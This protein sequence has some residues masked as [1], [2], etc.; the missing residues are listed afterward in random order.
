MCY[1]I[2]VIFG[3]W[4]VLTFSRLFRRNAPEVLPPRAQQAAFDVFLS[5]DRDDFQFAVR[6]NSTFSSEGLAV[7]WDKKIPPGKRWDTFIPEKIGQSKSAV[8]L[9]SKRSVASDMVLEEALLAREQGKLLPALISPASIPFGFRRIEAAELIGWKGDQAHPEWKN[10]VAEVRTLAKNGAPVSPNN[11]GGEAQIVHGNSRGPLIFVA[12]ARS[13]YDIAKR[14]S[15][16]LRRYGASVFWD[17]EIPIGTVFSE[18]IQ[19]TL[20]QASCVLALWSTQS[21]HS[22]WVRA[23]ADFARQQNK[24]ISVLLDD[25]ELPAPFGDDDQKIDL[26]ARPQEL[27]GRTWEEIKIVIGR[28]PNKELRS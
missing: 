15:D 20:E 9:W 28:Y 10:L 17:P 2:A 16:G 23:E 12:Y 1:L 13:D 4:S 18:V 27:D 3:V 11:A 6:V 22:P 21:V 5:Y 25:V 19:N 7:W 24:L 14:F 8:V 26:R